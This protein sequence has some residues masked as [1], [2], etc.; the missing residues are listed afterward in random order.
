METLNDIQS[1]AFMAIGPA[2]IAALSLLLPASQA[3]SEEAKIARRLSQDR[4]KAAHD[5][6][7]TGLLAMLAEFDHQL[8]APLEEQRCDCFD[9]LDPLVR[10]LE[11]PNLIQTSGFDAHC[12][13]K[14]EPTISKFLKEM[15]THL[16]E[17]QRQKEQARA[18]E[19]MQAVKNAEGVG[20]NI[21]LIAFNASIE[22][23]RLGDQGKG[24]TVIA[25]EIRDL[26]GKTQR[27]LD[28]I[29][30]LLIKS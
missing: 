22:A 19:M 13:F 1:K 23:A 4:I 11:D 21:Q 14:L 3:E 8:P 7:E 10:A 16:Q 5:M 12:L 29:S 6:L 15:T 28:T 17:A 26:A 27:I 9:T 25:S 24:F 20:K 30:E 18:E 2:R